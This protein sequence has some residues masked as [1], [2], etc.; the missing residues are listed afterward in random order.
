MRNAFQL[1]CRTKAA[2]AL[3]LTAVLALTA[4]HGGGS[5]GA[6][7]MTSYSSNASRS[8]TP[9]LFTIPEDQMEHVQVVTAIGDAQRNRA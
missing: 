5:A 6:G 1:S 7:E 9:K 3:A 2:G 8:D 4:C